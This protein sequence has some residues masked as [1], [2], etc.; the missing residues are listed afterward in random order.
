MEV[1]LHIPNKEYASELMAEGLSYFLRDRV[2]KYVDENNLTLKEK[3][4]IYEYLIKE[5][6]KDIEKLL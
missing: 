4:N 2:D 1:V 5:I 6:E 3:T